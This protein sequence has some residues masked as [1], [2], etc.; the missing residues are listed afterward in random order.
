MKDAVVHCKQVLQAGTSLKMLVNHT[1][2]LLECAP[3]IVL[4]KA[5]ASSEAVVK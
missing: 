2:L 5:A 3:A 1:L 4:L